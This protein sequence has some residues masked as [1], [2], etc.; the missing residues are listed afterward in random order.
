MKY[1]MCITSFF[2]ACWIQINDCY[3]ET[4]IFFSLFKLKSANNVINTFNFVTL[5]YIFY[6]ILIDINLLRNI[7]LISVH[8]I[9][10]SY[11]S[12]HHYSQIFIDVNHLLRKDIID[13]MSFRCILIPILSIKDNDKNVIKYI[14]ICVLWGSKGEEIIWMNHFQSELRVILNF[15]CFS[16]E[17]KIKK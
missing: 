6:Q 12:K 17:W 1:I 14:F 16:V 5:T 2:F 11:Y 8:F 13:F 4:Q 15:V 9:S 3:T 7:S 10:L